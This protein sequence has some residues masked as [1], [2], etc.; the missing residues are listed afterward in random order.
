MKTGRKWKSSSPEPTHAKV[1]RRELRA[2]A[3][4]RLTF[5]PEKRIFTPSKRKVPNT[6]SPRRHSSRF[7]C[8]GQET[9]TVQ[10]EHLKDMIVLVLIKFKWIKCKWISP[11]MVKAIKRVIRFIGCMLNRKLKCSNHWFMNLENIPKPTHFT[12]FIWL[13]GAWISLI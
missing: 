8:H 1:A 11:H 2:H 4:S 7:K 12:P 6:S 3:E 9:G 10:Y 13:I 5:S